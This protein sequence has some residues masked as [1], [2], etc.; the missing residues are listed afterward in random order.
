MMAETPSST[1]LNPASN[2]PGSDIPSEI[3][4]Q[5]LAERVKRAIRHQQGAAKF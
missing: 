1:N 2:K 4:C 5:H 3:D